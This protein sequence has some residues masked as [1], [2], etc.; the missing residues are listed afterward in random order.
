MRKP[1]SFSRFRFSCF[2]VNNKQNFFEKVP[3]PLTKLSLVVTRGTVQQ[4]NKTSLFEKLSV[5]FS[6][7]A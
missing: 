4:R 7:E 6:V 1:R 3:T 5:F 2:A